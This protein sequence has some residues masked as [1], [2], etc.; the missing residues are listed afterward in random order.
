MK[1]LSVI[2]IAHNEEQAISY[3]MTAAGKGLFGRDKT[4]QRA[5][6]DLSFGPSNLRQARRRGD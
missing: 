3:V 4:Y 1:A 2:L 5:I 6:L